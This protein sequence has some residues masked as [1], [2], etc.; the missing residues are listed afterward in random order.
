MPNCGY[1]GTIYLYFTT[2]AYSLFH[3]FTHPFGPFV[4]K[5]TSMA[6]TSNCANNFQKRNHQD[7]ELQYVLIQRK[8]LKGVLRRMAFDGTSASRPWYTHPSVSATIRVPRA[9]RWERQDGN[10]HLNTR[11]RCP[12]SVKW[13][14]SFISEGGGGSVCHD[15]DDGD[16]D[17]PSTSY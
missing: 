14:S 6:P 1:V 13:A 10:M 16:G 2:K 3:P 17:R 7:F 5:G 12:L 4:S 8:A 9:H 11:S 15:D